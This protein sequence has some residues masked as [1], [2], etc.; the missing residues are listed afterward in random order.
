MRDFLSLD[1]PLRNSDALL[2]N[3]EVVKNATAL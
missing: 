1:S 3:A 2:D